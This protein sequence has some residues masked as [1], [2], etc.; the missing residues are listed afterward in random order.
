MT[1]PIRN[2]I[3]GLVLASSLIFLTLFISINMDAF[4]AKAQSAVDV[5]QK[6]TD[7]EKKLIEL[8]KKIQGYQGEIQKTRTQQASLSNEIKL[9]NN[10]II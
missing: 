5:S 7:L 9:Y 3:I 2:K 1:Y 4:P 10:Q 6:K 8:N